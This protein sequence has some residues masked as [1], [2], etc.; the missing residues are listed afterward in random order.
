MAVNNAYRV[1]EKQ[2]TIAGLNINNDKTNAV[3]QTG[4]QLRDKVIHSN[5]T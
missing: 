1:V 2:V 5:N 3:I 4:E